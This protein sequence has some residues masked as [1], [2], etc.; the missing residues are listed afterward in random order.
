MDSPAVVA[1]AGMGGEAR[2]LMAPALAVLVLLE[3]NLGNLQVTLGG[4]E[5]DSW[6]SLHVISVEVEHAS[7][8]DPWAF[9]QKALVSLDWDSDCQ[10]GRMEHQGDF[11]LVFPFDRLMLQSLE[12]VH[13]IEQADR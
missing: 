3:G 2:N 9:H 11:C 7:Q 5:M 10:G 1:S 13:V 8:P 6:G 4:R 12:S